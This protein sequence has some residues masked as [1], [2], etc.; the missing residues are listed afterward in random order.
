MLLEKL[1]LT[2]VTYPNQ[3]HLHYFGGIKQLLY[4]NILSNDY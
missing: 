2:A 1:C 3:F 4:M